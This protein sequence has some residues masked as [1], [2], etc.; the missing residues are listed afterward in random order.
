[1]KLSR[2]ACLATCIVLLSVM[3]PITAQPTSP[4][5]PDQILKSAVAQ[6]PEKTLT[7]PLLFGAAM[8]SSTSFRALK[9]NFFRAEGAKQSADSGLDWTLSGDYSKL[10]YEP[11]TVSTTSPSEQKVDRWGVGLSKALT[12]G[13]ALSLSLGSSNNSIFFDSPLFKV[14]AYKE[15]KLT[16]TLS[17]NLWADSFGLA[18]RSGR[19]ASLRNSEALELGA[20]EAVEDWSIGFISIY[21]RAWLKQQALFAAKTNLEGRKRLLDVTQIKTGRGTAESVDLLQ[22]RAA[23]LAA[24]NQVLAAQ[25]DLDEEWRTLVLSLEL[26]TEWLL[27]DTSK[28][29][30]AL[31]APTSRASDLCRTKVSE[32]EILAVRRAE[33]SFEAAQLNL[34]KASSRLNPTL[35]LVGSYETNGIDSEFSVASQEALA[36]SNPSWSVGLNFKMPLGFSSE[37]ANYL[38]AQADLV[39]AETNRQSVIDNKKVAL[40]TTCD[41]YRKGKEQLENNQQAFQAQARRLALEEQR[42][43]LGRSTTTQ[44]I[45]AGDDRTRAEQA[46]RQ[47][48]VEFRLAAWNVLNSQSRVA[49]EVRAWAKGVS[50]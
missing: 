14:P 40:S 36:R 48:D 30:I 23:W 37:K 50:L 9:A 3:R 20:L 24:K 4:A 35:Q 21:Y 2:R 43:R 12:T 38:S 42:F 44:V 8:K 32:S 1:M 16:F 25:A 41:R 26:P 22:V 19:E 49:D 11:D 31:D 7:L 17:Q 33:K 46:L 6:L 34:E 15:S 45:Q 29:P 28:I 27:V 10:H 18:T 5:D 39:A 47:L 13:T